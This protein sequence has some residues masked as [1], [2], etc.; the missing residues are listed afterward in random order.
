VTSGSSFACGSCRHHRGGPCH[1]ATIFGI[2][3]VRVRRIAYGRGCA[4]SASSAIGDSVCWWA[5][6]TRE[7]EFVGACPAFPPRG[8]PATATR[9]A[10]TART[11]AHLAPPRL[12]R[13]AIARI[14]PG[15]SNVL[16]APHPEARRP[17]PVSRVSGTLSRTLSVTLQLG[18]THGFSGS[19]AG[20]TADAGYV[21]MSVELEGY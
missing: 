14:S 8:C 19:F 15:T 13:A 3:V 2:W 21:A 6:K 20:E 7:G 11:R 5:S 9:D 10:S 18:S 16:A 12:S 4:W 17:N 1:F